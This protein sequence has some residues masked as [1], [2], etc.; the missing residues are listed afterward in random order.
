MV[1]KVV[2]MANGT[3]IFSIAKETNI[4]DADDNISVRTDDIFGEIDGRLILHLI[5]TLFYHLLLT[6]PK[7]LKYCLRNQYS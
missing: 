5:T 7:F 3:N 2:A 4:F 6:C 1:P